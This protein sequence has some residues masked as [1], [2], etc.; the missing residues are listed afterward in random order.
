[1]AT[2]GYVEQLIGPVEGGLKSVLK[3]VFDYVLAEVR[4]GRPDDQ[5]KSENFYGH[6]YWGTTPASA[7]TEFTIAH[8]KGRTPYLLIPVL[9]LDTV[10]NQLVPL[11]V[12]RAADATRVYLK[13]TATSAPFV[14]MIEG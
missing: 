2:T 14:V 10:G 11:E 5:G 13:S 3:R 9:P 4:F 12:T 8:G 7:G 1:M 6:F